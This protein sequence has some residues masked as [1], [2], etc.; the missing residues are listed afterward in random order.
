VLGIPRASNETQVKEAYFRLARRFHPDAH[1]DAT[2]SDMRDQ[3]EAVFIRLGEAYEVLRNAR[4]RSGYEADLVARMPRVPVGSSPSGPS[5]APAAPPP[6][7]PEAEARMADDAIRKAERLFS[8]DKYWDAIQL[9]E[10][11]VAVTQ[12]TLRPKGQ[13]LLARAY[14]KNPKWVKRGEELLQA[15]IK[16]DPRNVTAHFVLA[17]IYRDGGLKSRAQAMF[18][19]VLELKP[20]HEEALAEMA[21]AATEPPPSGGIIKKLFGKT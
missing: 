18:R 16:A 12:A 13:I 10:P 21:G 8:Q 1:H 14:T 17:T 15:V 4:T 5:A 11:A 2:L 6:P 20:D 9:L 7:D 3:L 19:K